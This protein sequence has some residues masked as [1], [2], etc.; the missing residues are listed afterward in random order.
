M[1]GHFMDGKDVDE[2]SVLD[3]KFEAY[4]LCT[5]EFAGSDNEGD[6]DMYEE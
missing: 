4:F 5:G 6:T 1:K 2:R 3:A